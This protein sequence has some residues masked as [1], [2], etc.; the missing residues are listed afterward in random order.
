MITIDHIPL[1][2]YDIFALRKQVAVVLQDVFL[3]SGTIFEN[4]TMKDE[5]FSK[6]QVISVCKDLDIHD[7]IMK[8]PGG[9]DFNV[10]ERGGTLSQGQRQ[11]ISFARALIFDPSI[12]ILD[13]A[14]A[15][16][17]SNSEQMVQNAIEKLIQGRTSIVIAHRL[18]TIRKSD[19]IIVLEKG[20]VIEQGT[21]QELIANDGYYNQMY[22]ATLDQ[23]HT[24]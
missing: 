19:K 13:E 11:L 1:Q 22:L 14:T 9:Y 2:D 24:A 17:D 6:D 3:F 4:I 16:V 7:F 5:R 15:S 10:Q 8:L 18:S 21:H 12:L 23:K 20:Q